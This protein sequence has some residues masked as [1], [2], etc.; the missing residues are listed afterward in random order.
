MKTSLNKLHWKSISTIS[1]ALLKISGLMGFCFLIEACYGTVQN[2]ET[3]SGKYLLRGK[4]S[5]KLDSLGVNNMKMRLNTENGDYITQTDSTGQFSF[6]VLELSVGNHK[7][8]AENQLGTT[9]F[10]SIIHFPPT[11]SI[12]TIEINVFIDKGKK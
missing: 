10:D 2:F 4:V 12:D 8:T 5:S 3:P 6:K 11:T 1:K 7:L 9:Q